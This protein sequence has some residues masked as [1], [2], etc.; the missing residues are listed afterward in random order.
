MGSNKRLL[1]MAYGISPYHDFCTQPHAALI[2]VLLLGKDL[3]AIWKES[4]YEVRHAR[5]IQL[6]HGRN[7]PA[8]IMQINYLLAFSH[9]Y[10]KNKNKPS[11]VQS[12]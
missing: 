7:G 6:K 4:S 10:N 9:E 5:L 3:S 11:E 12:E 1:G 8:S 2:M